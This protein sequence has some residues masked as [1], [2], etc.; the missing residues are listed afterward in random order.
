MVS[1][2]FKRSRSDRFYSTRCC[3]CCHVRTG[4]II[5]GTSYMVRAAGGAEAPGDC[6]WEGGGGGPVRKEAC[7]L[8]AADLNGVGSGGKAASR[9]CSPFAGATAAESAGWTGG[10]LE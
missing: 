10:G 4:T 7:P 1:M 5:L 6:A 9:G 8:R 2:T 3:G